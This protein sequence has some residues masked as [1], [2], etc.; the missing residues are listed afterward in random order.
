MATTNIA[1]AGAGAVG[2][3]IIDELKSHPQYKV[4]ILTR[5][6]RTPHSVLPQSIPF[7]AHR[8]EPVRKQN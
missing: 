8:V 4:F 3:A 7:N 5:D 1:I 2:R 6:V